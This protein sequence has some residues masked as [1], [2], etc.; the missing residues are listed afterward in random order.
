VLKLEFRNGT[1]KQTRPLVSS[2]RTT[3]VIKWQRH[4]GVSDRRYTPAD[5]FV[6]GQ[7][8]YA[9]DARVTVSTLCKPVLQDDV[10]FGTCLYEWDGTEWILLTDNCSEIAEAVAPVSP[11]TTIGEQRA[12]TC[13]I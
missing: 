7:I 4:V 10:D 6:G 1:A 9:T 13:V 12:G 11:G 5:T 2:N 8:Q 3:G